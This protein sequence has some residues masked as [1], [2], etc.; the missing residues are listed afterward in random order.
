MA[1]ETL[2]HV[3]TQLETLFNHGTLGGL[4]DSELLGRFLTGDAALAD[5]AFTVIVDR[6]GPMVM[7][8]LP[9]CSG[10]DARRGGRLPGGLPGPGSSR[11]I[12]PPARIGG[13]LA[14]RRRPSG[15]GESATRRRPA[16]QA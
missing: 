9:Q 3:H 1:T 15:R 8:G 12:G 14:L 5:A 6:H 4:T 7:C 16:A 11:Q 13:K 2:T 10:H